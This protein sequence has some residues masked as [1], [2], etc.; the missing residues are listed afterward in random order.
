M[1]NKK[2]I[3]FETVKIIVGSKHSII[4]DL[5]RECVFH[6]PNSIKEFVDLCYGKTIREIFKYYSFDLS[7]TKR[8]LKF[9]LE[10]ELCCFVND[11]ELFPKLSEHWD[12]PF[13]I[14]N[15]LIDIQEQQNITQL[16]LSL[17]NMIIPYLSLRIYQ[18][19]DTKYLLNLIFLLERKIYIGYTV[20]LPYDPLNN[21]E[22]VQEIIKSNKC[23]LIIFYNAPTTNR[24]VSSNI[25]KDILITS[26]T[27]S[28]H[29]DCGKISGFFN[30]N[31]K[32]YT[33]SLYFNSCL[34]RKIS[35]DAN[36][37]IKNCPSMIESFGNISNTTLE[38]AINKVNFK[39]NWD[40]NKD[41]IHVCKDCEFRYICTDCRAFVE[42]PDDNLSK[43]L[44]CGYNPYTGEWSEWST[45]PLKQKAIQYYGMEEIGAE[46]AEGLKVS[47]EE[48]S[49]EK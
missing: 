26:E 31:I 32:T 16:S 36:G 40:I 41:K 42:N 7:N 35:I 3:L 17:G 22:I 8:Y 37:D 34:N 46:R 30:P 20:Y 29:L 47:S 13:E 27:I 11:I 38:E 4:V 45:N 25:N 48:T 5:Q 15:S 23:Y 49:S 39:K 21:N 18:K 10:N 9:L 44:K 1:D 24:I 43:P 2:L 6:L 28:S 12:S 14:T 33:E 19:H